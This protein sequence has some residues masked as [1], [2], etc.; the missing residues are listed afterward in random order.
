MVKRTLFIALLAVCSSMQMTALGQK[1][2][3]IKL[4]NPSF[5][6]YPQAGRQPA[7]WFDCGF[8]GETPPDVNPTGQF[9]VSKNAYHGSTY[10][11]MVTRDNNTW[12]GVGQRLKTPLMKG[13]VYTFSIY[14]ARSE[15]Y[16]SQSRATGRDVNYVTPA[17][18]RIWGGSGYC[19]KEEMLGETEPI[20]A[21]TWQKFN[22]K[23][24]PKGTH[25]YFMIEAFYKVP[26][27]FPYN[28]NVLVDNASDLVPEI[29]KDE[30]KVV[31]QVT[32]NPK[33]PTP[34][35]PPVVEQPKPPAVSIAKPN[36]NATVLT[37]SVELRAV[38]SNITEKSQISVT[39]NNNELTDFVF[40]KSSRL[41]KANLKLNEGSNTLTVRV[42]NKDGEVSVSSVVNYTAPV[43][44]AST[45]PEKLKEGSI[46]KIE[47]LQFAPNSAEIEKESFSS[48]DEIYNLLVS[49]PHMIVEIGGHTNLVIEE[50]ESYILSTNRAKAVAYYL[51]S[52]GIE[53]KRLLTKGY[54]KSL[55][56]ENNKSQAANKANQRVEI[57]ILSTSG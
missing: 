35:K 37:P 47:K 8:A 33:A 19:S 6:D 49:N 17:T 55:P 14:L 46:I 45:T 21:A 50:G 3:V 13:I 51:A 2:V 41:V 32:P 16:M 12:E 56:I 34:T 53:K 52:K 31:A 4:D 27:L 25:N 9:K 42:K 20:S 22:F 54:G 10:L 24:T 57:K 39:C 48:L 26:T 29:K 28:G 43:V 40:D 18:L 7:G 36:N 11:G 1:P 15:I 5:E 38:V 23:F 30:P 44:A